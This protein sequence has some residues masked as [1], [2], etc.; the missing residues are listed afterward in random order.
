[1]KSYPSIPTIGTHLIDSDRKLPVDITADNW[2]G[3]DK[4]DGSLVRTEWKH[5]RGFYKFG[6]RG[7]LLDDSNPWLIEAPGIIEER[8]AFLK[9]VFK[10]FGWMQVTVFFEFLGKNSFAGDHQ[11]EPHTANLIDVSTHPK[12]LI[13]P[14]E[15]IAMDIVGGA[16][17]VHRGPVDSELIHKIA[18]GKLKGV[19][20]EGV[21]FKRINRKGIREMFKS[22]SAA[23]YEKLRE[24]CGR[25]DKLFERSK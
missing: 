22:K 1:M 20:F 10:D 23:W 16:R 15:L 25:N 7:G 13:D 11:P 12:G 2:I 8:Y 9:E 24:K 19:T 6:R 21:V 4:L 14:K 17:L 3:F 5:G 18:D